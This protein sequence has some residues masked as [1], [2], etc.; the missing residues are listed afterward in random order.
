MNLWLIF[1]LIGIAAFLIRISFIALI[2]RRQFPEWLRRA[3]R[4]VPA[5][6]FAAIVVPELVYR[7]GVFTPF[8]PQLG[9]GLVA[10]VVAW[11]TRSVLLTI[12][13]GIAVLWLLNT[14]MAR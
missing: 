4:F 12:G 6:V 2:G 3:L 13:G 8:S 7:A 10:I 14:L 11:R 9:A 1:I 5:A